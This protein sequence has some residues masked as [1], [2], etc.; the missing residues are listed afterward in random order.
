MGVRGSVFRSTIF[1]RDATVGQA[2]KHHRD[3]ESDKRQVYQTLCG[4]PMTPAIA[5]NLVFSW[6]PIDHPGLCLECRKLREVL[7]AEGKWPKI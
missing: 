4:I 3:Y 2:M 1:R 6:A 7:E 5:S